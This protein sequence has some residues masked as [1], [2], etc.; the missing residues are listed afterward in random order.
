MSVRKVVVTGA[1]RGIGFKIAEA[2]AKQGDFVAVCDINK[3]GAEAAAKKIGPHAE[4][5]HVD[6]TDEANVRTFMNDFYQEHQA[7]HVL[8]NNAG[9][10]HLDKIEDFPLAKWNQL[11]DVML[12]GPFLMTKHALPFMKEKR[13]GRIVNIS[14]VHGKVASPYKAAYIA[15]KHGV[16][17]FTRT[18]A[19]ETAAFGITANTVMPGP[20][21]TELLMKQFAQLQE[22]KNLTEAEAF[23]EIL[24]PRQAIKKFVE[25]EEIANTV[26]FLASE[27]AQSITGENISVSYGI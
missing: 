18:T 12:T 19:I 6:I 23:D 27:H 20:V 7:I 14:S 11:L 9:M 3:T 4:A 2:F 24:W 25:P 1:A 8:I 5:Y 10:Q 21:K 22:E 26:I 15:A 13:F 17:G 16:V